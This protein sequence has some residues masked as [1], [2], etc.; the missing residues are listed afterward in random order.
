[1]KGFIPKHG[2][3][4]LEAAQSFWRVDDSD[5]VYSLSCASHVERLVVWCFQKEQVCSTRES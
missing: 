1:M 2:S 3:Q 5:G 4:K